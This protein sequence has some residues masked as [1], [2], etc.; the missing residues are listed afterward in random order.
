M[1]TTHCVARDAHS[2]VSHAISLLERIRPKT[3]SPGFTIVELLLVI[4]VIAILTTVSVV[5]YNG[6]TQRAYNTRQIAAAR[7]V[8]TLFSIYQSFYGKNPATVDG[9]YNSGGVCLTVDK[10]CT[11]Y[12]G[13]D[14]SGVDNSTLMTELRR[15]GTP[16]QSAPGQVTNAYVTVKGLYLDYNDWRYYNGSPAPYLMIFWLRGEKQNCSLSNT[17]MADPN[18]TTI[19]PGPDNNWVGYQNFIASTKGYSFSI[20]D[21]STDVNLTECFIRL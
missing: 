3:T 7:Q 2:P 6:V 13:R 21:D 9:S 16:P 19:E 10:Q 17:V 18:S 4:V 11:D 8:Q 14:M 15:V 1:L 5:A 20:D 12:A